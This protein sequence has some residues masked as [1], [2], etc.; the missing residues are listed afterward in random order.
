VA[1]SSG[2]LMPAAR[3]TSQRI[4]GPGPRRTSRRKRQSL[5]R[6]LT[7]HESAWLALP[8]LP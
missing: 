1:G 7:W 2:V 6:R 5:L 8:S 3:G 4:I